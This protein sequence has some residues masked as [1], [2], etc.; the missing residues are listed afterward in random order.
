[1]CLK[2]T[3]T[4]VRSGPILEPSATRLPSASVTTAFR[5]DP[6]VTPFGI[7]VPSSGTAQ[8]GGA[9]V[10]AEAYNR[11][12]V[13]VVVVPR[14]AVRVVVDDNGWCCWNASTAA[15][16][17]TAA[18]T[19]AWN[20]IFSSYVV[21]PAGL[22]T[23]MSNRRPFIARHGLASCFLV[24]ANLIHQKLKCRSES[25]DDVGTVP[26]TVLHKKVMLH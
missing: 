5:I 4:A 8:G 2:K 3:T 19:A 17:A 18:T 13:V 22:V 7:V 24:A 1:M 15:A 16:A 6:A 21:G 10:P 12:V 11:V 23:A 26:Y 9:A 20:L 25:G 14:K